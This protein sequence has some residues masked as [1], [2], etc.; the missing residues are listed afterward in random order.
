MKKF[1]DHA[2]GSVSL[3]FSKYYFKLYINVNKI[4][5][6]SV[7]LYPQSDIGML[8]PNKKIPKCSILLIQKFLSRQKFQLG[9]GKQIIM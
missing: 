8:D 9:N 1:I 7:Y 2:T 4:I 5:A 3:L 6:D